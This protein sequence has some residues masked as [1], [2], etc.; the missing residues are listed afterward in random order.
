MKVQDVNCSDL[1]K[2]VDEKIHD[3]RNRK[4]IKRRLID[5]ISYGQLSF[6]FFLTD[7]QIKNIVKKAKVIMGL[8]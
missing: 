5:G 4:I 3:E 6:E 8:E 1:R 2:M 7:R